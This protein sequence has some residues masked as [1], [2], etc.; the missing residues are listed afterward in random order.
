MRFHT[1]QS[2]DVAYFKRIVPSVLTGTAEELSRYNRDWMGKFMGSSGVVLRPT[3][4]SQVSDILRYC[5]DR[6]IAVVPQSGNTGL[7]GGSVPVHSEVIVSMELMNRVENIDASRRLLK[8]ESGCVLGK[9]NADLLAHGLEMPLDMGSSGSC[10]VG[11]NVATNAGGIRYI[12]YGGMHSTVLGLEVVLPNGSTMDLNYSAA[13]MKDSTGLPIKDLFIGSEG[14]LGIITK[15]A[16]RL[17][18]KPSNPQLLLVR[19]SSSTNISDSEFAIPDFSAVEKVHYLTQRHRVQLS[20]FEAFNHCVLIESDVPFSEDFVSSL[21]NLF[22]S[23]SIAQSETE[24]QSMWRLREQMPVRASQR[25]KDLQKTLHKF[26]VSVPIHNYTE[27]CTDV[28]RIARDHLKDPGDPPTSI[29]GHY[30]DGNLHVNVV[31]TFSEA[32]ENEIYDAVC[33]YGG[34]VSA[35]H[36]I[37]LMKK[38]ALKKQKSAEAIRIM[39]GIKS[40]FDPHGI[41]NP[42]KVI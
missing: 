41:M 11:G 7:V 33:K 22:P 12:K 23:S 2:L 4:T 28:D 6:R 37:G 3:S 40:V 36:G 32:A 9:I 17:F 34:S 20:A 27:F 26:D 24:R 13:V 1:L 42:E 30:A 5:N 15:V 35:E 39:R 38:A 16:V 10:M 25:A 29:Y 21:S 19:T 8:C 31:G 18:A 14:L